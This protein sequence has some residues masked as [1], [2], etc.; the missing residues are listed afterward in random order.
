MREATIPPLPHAEL[1]RALSY[2][3]KT[4]VW[5]WRVSRGPNKAGDVAGTWRN[6]DGRR[7]VFVNGRVYLASR[8]AWF[9]MTGEWPT[10]LVEHKDTNPSN[11]AWDNLRLATT[12]QNSRNRGKNR[13][14]ST[15][16]KGVGRNRG[17]GKKFRAQIKVNGATLSLGYF[18]TAE[19]AARAYNAA[20][21]RHFGSFAQLNRIGRCSCRRSLPSLTGRFL[22]GAPFLMPRSGRAAY[23]QTRIASSDR[24]LACRACA[25]PPSRTQCA[26]Q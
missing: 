15:G 12:A 11:D 23:R 10:T 20:A 14:N 25:V 13:T 4:G 24:P 19:E 18:D 2:N 7:A 6:T 21:L 22:T 17:R 26:P 5:H 3:R 1:Q 9:Y 8:L 16:Y